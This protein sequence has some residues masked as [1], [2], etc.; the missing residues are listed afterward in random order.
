MRLLLDENLSPRLARAVND[1][2]PGSIHVGDVGLRSAD[3][4]TVWR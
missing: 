1:L 4:E 2:F 3:D